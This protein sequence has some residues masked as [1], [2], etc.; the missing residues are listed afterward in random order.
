MVYG[1]LPPD[2][3]IL[4]GHRPQ[5]GNEI[6]MASYLADTLETKVGD[7][8]LLTSTSELAQKF[9]VVGVY[10]KRQQCWADRRDVRRWA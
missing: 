3:E 1:T 2:G 7:S 9:C 10:R 8:V 6:M 5:N 4:Q